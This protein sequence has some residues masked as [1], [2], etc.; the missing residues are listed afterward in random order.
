MSDETFQEIMGRIAVITVDAKY[1]KQLKGEYENLIVD[2]LKQ[3]EACERSKTGQSEAMTAAALASKL[4]IEQAALDSVNRERAAT[5]SILDAKTDLERN[6]ET[7]IAEAVRKAKEEET[8]KL[9]AES[10]TA[11]AELALETKLKIAALEAALEDKTASEERIRRELDASNAANQLKSDE[12][13]RQEVAIAT[14]E[15][16]FNESMAALKAEQ[17]SASSSS[18]AEIDAKIAAIEAENRTLSAEKDALAREKQELES[19]LPARI[20][21]AVLAEREKLEAEQATLLEQQRTEIEAAEK[22]KLEDELKAIGVKL[23]ANKDQWSAEEIKKKI[24]EINFNLTSATAKL[25]E[26]SDKIAEEKSKLEQLSAEKLQEKNQAL[27]AEAKSRAR[28]VM[29]TQD[30]LKNVE[31]FKVAL[32]DLFRKKMEGTED[33]QTKTKIQGIISKLIQFKQD[34][35]SKSQLE[36]LQA[37]TDALTGE[38]TSLASKLAALQTAKIEVETQKGSSDEQIQTLKGQIEQIGQ[39]IKQIPMTNIDSIDGKVLDGGGM[40]VNVLEDFTIKN[41]DGTELPAKLDLKNELIRIVQEKVPDQIDF[42]RRIINEYF[43][44]TPA[45]ALAVRSAAKPQDGFAQVPQ[46]VGSLGF[47]EPAASA[48]GGQKKRSRRLRRPYKNTKRR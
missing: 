14:K 9:R 19:D 37:T 32:I 6:Q 40:N 4:A 2:L 35:T 11:A 39:K 15:A 20:N 33:P 12:I 45:G 36:L 3:L 21:E 10:D 43:G 24:G 38:N 28:E 47:K 48:M 7:V 41:G 22:K 46:G 44:E 25:S 26:S 8:E 29:R 42:M 17:A 34:A 16:G 31:R 13:S 23:Q 5:Q 27:T 1:N 18:K 30:K